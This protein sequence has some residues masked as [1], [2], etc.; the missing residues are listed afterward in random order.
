MNVPPVPRFRIDVDT[1][2]KAPAVV[3]PPLVS[4]TLVPFSER[5]PLTEVEAPR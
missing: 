5:R 1:P 4:T 3:V 2:V